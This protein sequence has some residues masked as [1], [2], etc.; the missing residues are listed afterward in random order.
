MYAGDYFADRNASCQLCKQPA[1]H[2]PCQDGFYYNRCASDAS[3]GTSDAT[4]QQCTNAPLAL[5]PEL[6]VRYT[7][8]GSQENLVGLNNCGWMCM[9]GY[10]LR[11]SLVTT[12]L[13]CSPCSST[14]CAAGQYRETC[15]QANR[16][17]N[18]GCLNCTQPVPLYGFLG[19]SEMPTS[20]SCP[21]LCQ[22]GWWYLASRNKCCS[23]HSIIF[24]KTGDCVCGSGFQTPS[25][26]LNGIVCTI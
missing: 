17:R 21:V 18:A 25:P 12:L 14:S 15:T 22:R 20:D 16:T 10:F 8:P 6:A 11:F 26:E 23:D 19:V 9:V 13:S 1:I 2:G 5:Q 24:K 4:C 3:E 7:S